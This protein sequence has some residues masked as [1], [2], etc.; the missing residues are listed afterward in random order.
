MHHETAHLAEEAAGVGRSDCAALEED[1]GALEIRVQ[2]A[3][4]VQVAHARA[5]VCQAQ[6]H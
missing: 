3:D 2:Q 1:V 5:Y 6:Q 4:G